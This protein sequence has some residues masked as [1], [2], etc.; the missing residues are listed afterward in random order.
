MSLMNPPP[1]WKEWVLFANMR[2]VDL[3]AQLGRFRHEV[4][5]SPQNPPEGDV[6]RILSRHTKTAAIGTPLNTA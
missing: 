5:K 3:L 6:W 4:I 2:G 1:L